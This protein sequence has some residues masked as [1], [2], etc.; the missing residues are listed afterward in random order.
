MNQQQ[1]IIDLVS[2]SFNSDIFKDTRKWNNCFPRQIAMTLLNRHTDL[3][4]KKIGKIFGRHY[5]TV[6]HARKHVND[7]CETEPE[8]K[9]KILEIEG[10]LQ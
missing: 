4:V 1:R 7:L 6:I 2:V 9:Q 8:V 5:S 3:G 10:C